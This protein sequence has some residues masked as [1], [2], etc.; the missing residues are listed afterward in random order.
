MEKA[1]R[2]F[3]LGACDAVFMIRGCTENDPVWDEGALHPFTEIGLSP[4]AAV[5]SYALSVFEGL[6]VHK[7]IDGKIRLF[8]GDAHAKR[9][10]HSAGA[11]LMPSLPTNL[12]L[13]A[14]EEVTRRNLQHVPPTGKGAFYLR[15]VLFAEEGRLGIE[16]C[17]DYRVVVYGTPVGSYFKGDQAKIRLRL[18]DRARVP[19]GGT[20]WAKASG[21]YGGNLAT[22]VHWKGRG[23]NDVLFV[24]AKH[25]RCLTECSGA[26]V[27][28]KLPDGTIVTP[29]LD[30]QILPGITRDSVITLL[31]DRGETVEERPLDSEEVFERSVEMFC[32]G[33][34]WTVQPVGVLTNDERDKEFAGHSTA[35][36]LRRELQAIQTGEVEDRFGW[37]SVIEV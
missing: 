20:G 6:K 14:V 16:V 2:G 34:A 26:N 33:T 17:K 4:A 35:A 3:G 13:H 11:L 37:T 12:F 19:D 18:L 27:F 15:P 36:S 7:G 23:F 29:P 8:R 25:G 28:V 30:D 24:D 32:T 22:A 31:R 5:L 9:F 21:N 10:Q 1:G